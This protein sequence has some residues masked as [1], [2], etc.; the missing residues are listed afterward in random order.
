M[1]LLR[2]GKKGASHRPHEG[3]IADVCLLF[4]NVL[5]FINFQYCLCKIQVQIHRPYGDYL[6]VVDF[7]AKLIKEF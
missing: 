1:S 7:R 3:R 2:L 5:S 4:T 6:S